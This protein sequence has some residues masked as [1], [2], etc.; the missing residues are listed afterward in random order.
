MKAFISFKYCNNSS[1]KGSTKI[2]SIV[3]CL[4]SS[5]YMTFLPNYP[6]IL[7]KVY[8]ICLVVFKFGINIYKRKEIKNDF[9]V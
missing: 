4:L 9:I 1:T 8:S 3:D 6:Q 2:G 7:E 5:F